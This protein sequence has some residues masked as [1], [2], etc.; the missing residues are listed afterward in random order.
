MKIF[1]YGLMSMTMLYLAACDSSQ[2]GQAV[3][4][5]SAP[6]QV[7]ES[8]A[9]AG[10]RTQRQAGDPLPTISSASNQDDGFTEIDWDALMPE[11]FRPEQLLM[12]YMDQIAALPDD[13]DPRALELYGIMQ[14]EL[15]NAPINKALA[16]KSVKLPGFIAPLENVDGKVSEFLLVPY[17]GACIHVPPPPV[18][19]TVL[20]KTL[21]DS[22][23]DAEDWMEPVWVLGKIQAEGES[24]DIGNAGYRIMDARVEI[25]EY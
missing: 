22:A 24:T 2:P 20:V 25:F 3:S 7:T 5:E 9:D 1:F 10:S 16:G 11:D 4:S 15:N 13:D 8:P 12:K 14:A 19:Q 23:I 6:Q 21:A 18:N 17:F